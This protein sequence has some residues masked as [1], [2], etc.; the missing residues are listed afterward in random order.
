MVR[1][2][3]V[4][5]IW[6]RLLTLLVGSVLLDF[7]GLLKKVKMAGSNIFRIIMVTYETKNV[8]IESSAVIINIWGLIIAEIRL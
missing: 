8:I 3:A 6:L 4:V 7:R 1:I 2:G 5:R